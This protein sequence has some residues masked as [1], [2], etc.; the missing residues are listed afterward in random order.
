MNYKLTN[1]LN[2]N[3]IKEKIDK[4]KHY[5]NSKILNYKWKWFTILIKILQKNFNEN[6]KYQILNK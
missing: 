2:V 5:Y 4:R 1:K 6:F 3:E